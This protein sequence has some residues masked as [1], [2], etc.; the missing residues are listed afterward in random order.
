MGKA[1][2]ALSSPFLAAKDLKDNQAR[3]QENIS[4][5]GLSPATIDGKDISL[6]TLD[7][8]IM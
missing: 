3:L 1:A 6:E 8:Y 4:K 5:L 7:R 2:E